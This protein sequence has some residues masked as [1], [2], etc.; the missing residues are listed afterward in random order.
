MPELRPG[1]PISIHAPVRG[2]TRISQTHRRLLTNFNPRSREGSDANC[3][4]VSPNLW[5]FNPRSREGSDTQVVPRYLPK[6][7]FNPRSREGSDSNFNQFFLFFFIHFYHFLYFTSNF[8][9]VFQKY[10]L[11]LTV[12]SSFFWCESPRYFLS[13]SHS[14]HF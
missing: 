12:I 14:H 9:S 1:L 5:H 6:S 8:F 3:T 13:T 10:N 4:C 11:F 7:D 2:A